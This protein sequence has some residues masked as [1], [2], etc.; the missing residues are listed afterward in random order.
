MK[1]IGNR[2]IEKGANISADRVYRYSLW[3]IWEPTQPLV[4]FI[5]LNPSTADATTDDHTIRRCLW[6]SSDWGYGGLVMTNLFA[7]RATDPKGMLAAPSPVG[8]KNDRVIT[9]WAQRASVIVA[10]WG[11]KGQH[12][13]R[14]QAIASQFSNLYC[15]GVT[16]DGYPHHPA[17][18]RSDTELV[19]YSGLDGQILKPVG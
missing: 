17:R 9:Q 2:T 11:T 10:I 5:G 13:E 16:K 6:F 18:L 8:S 19:K 15:L 12:M 3:R 4:M 1:A 7:F 14:H